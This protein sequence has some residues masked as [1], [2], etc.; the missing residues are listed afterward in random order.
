MR[1]LVLTLLGVAAGLWLAVLFQASPQPLS[2]ASTEGSEPTQLA[3]ERL[4]GEQQAL[5]TT[6]AELRQQLAERQ[7]AVSAQT[8][9]LEALERE[10][11]R[12]RL[13]AGLVPVQGPGVQV[14]LDDSDVQVPAAADPNVYLIHEYDLRDTVNLLWLAGAEAVAINEERLV[15]TSSI[16][17]VGSTVLVNATRLS[18]PY[19][20]RAIGD[21]DALKQQLDNPSYLK[22]LKDKQRLYGLRFEVEPMLAVSLQGYSGG[23]L[24]Q[25]AGPGE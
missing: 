17:C 12:Q 6:L 8:G 2:G 5:K 23:F 18:P 10:L 22:S 1:G 21:P 19:R 4:E 25:F 24:T 9:Q 11:E 7:Q 14:T 13:L 15:S 16:Y 3:I 20:V